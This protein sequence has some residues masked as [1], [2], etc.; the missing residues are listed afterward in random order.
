MTLYKSHIAIA[1]RDRFIAYILQHVAIFLQY[2]IL[3]IFI[4]IHMYDKA[5][6]NIYNIAFTCEILTVL[7][8]AA[9]VHSIAMNLCH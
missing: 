6:V 7:Y 8:T 5:Q 3:V 4:H 1:K 2:L 9:R